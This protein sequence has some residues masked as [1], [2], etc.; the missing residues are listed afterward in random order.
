MTKAEAARILKGHNEWRRGGD[1][2]HVHP[3]QLGIAIDV[4]VRVLTPKPKLIAS[5]QKPKR[6]P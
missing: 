1:G 5:E 2:Q 4:A 6:N 3:S